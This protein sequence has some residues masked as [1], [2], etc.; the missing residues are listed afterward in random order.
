MSAVDPMVPDEREAKLPVWARTL[1]DSLRRR[2]RQAERLAAR[3]A[4]DTDPDGSGAILDR[5]ADHPIGLG[6]L[7]QVSFR[8]PFPRH[9]EGFI[10]VGQIVGKGGI[11]G[12]ITIHASE[13][14]V[15]RP[16]ATNAIEVVPWPKR[17]TGD[18]C[19]NAWHLS[20]PARND[21]GCPECPYVCTRCATR[22]PAPNLLREHMTRC[23]R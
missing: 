20:A 10:E 15:C 11:V 7:P 1:L 18:A 23:G 9:P 2:T 6:D 17:S 8:V 19:S 21:Q 12:G 4:L 22:R 5:F 3:A 16:R 14:V 13:E